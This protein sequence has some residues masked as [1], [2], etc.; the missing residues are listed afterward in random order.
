MIMDS[1]K[2]YKHIYAIAGVIDFI[3]AEAIA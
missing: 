3:K 2:A 1:I